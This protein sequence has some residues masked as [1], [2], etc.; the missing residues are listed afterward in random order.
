MNSKLYTDVV[1]KQLAKHA[2]KLAKQNFISQQDNSAVHTAKVV[3]AYFHCKGIY[4]LPWPAR[5]LDLN[6]TENCWEV[7]ATAV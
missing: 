2:A 6:I 1:N 7:V 5:S 4:I 3:Q